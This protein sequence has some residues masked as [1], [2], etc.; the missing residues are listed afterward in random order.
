[1]DYEL[2]FFISYILVLIFGMLAIT[3]N[4]I[5]LSLLFVLT[6]TVSLYCYMKSQ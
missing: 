5:V 6:A 3:I 1:M 2:G 4:S